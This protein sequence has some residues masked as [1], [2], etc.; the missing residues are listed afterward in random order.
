MLL[1]SSIVI[2]ILFGS[3]PAHGQGTG[4]PLA[5]AIR[6]DSLGKHEQ[7][8]KLYNEA[9]KDPA[10]RSE[11][12]RRLAGCEFDHLHRFEDAFVHIQQ[13]I[14]AAPK[15]YGNYLDRSTMYQQV[16][17]PERS[18]DDLNAALALADSVP[19]RVNV[20]TNLGAAYLQMHDAKHAAEATAKAV[21][22]DSTDIG[23]RMNHATALDELGRREEALAIMIKL[24]Q[25][26]PE[27]TSYMNNIGFIL[28]NMDRHAE[29]VQWL[30]KSL[31]I[32]KDEPY[33]LNNRGYSK[34]KMGDTAGAL[35]DVQRSLKLYALNAYAYRNLGLI[36]KEMGEQDKA[37]DAFEAALSHDFT[38]MYG[39]EVK[40]IHDSYCH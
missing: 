1:R 38:K 12:M 2:G 34:L 4:A 5:Q 11:A 31:D 30:D 40:R 22:L 20:Y 33:A 18:L 21:A 10:H 23:A 9:A 32:K 17:M 8:V 15:E 14:Q 29:A 27:N 35:K 3:M 7:A 25:E 37:C 13:A 28:A 19:D 39:D 24:S 6:L 36:Y 26:D 16:G